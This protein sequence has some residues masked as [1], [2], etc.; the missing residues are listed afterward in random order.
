M[1]RLSQLLPLLLAAC[2]SPPPATPHLA[3][4]TLT[5][6]ADGLRPGPTLRVP[7]FGAVVFRNAEPASTAEVTVDRPLAPTEACAST[8]GFD[9]HGEHSRTQPLPPRGL[10]S[11]CFHDE[12]TFAFSVAIGGRTFEGT[13]V[14]GGR[15]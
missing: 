4:D 1:P 13:I 9:D 8:L 14:V 7:R 5:I 12:G 15:P 6:T 3:A 11:L 10:A 2:V